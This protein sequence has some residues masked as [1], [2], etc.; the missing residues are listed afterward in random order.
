MTTELATRPHNLVLTDP[1]RSL[2]LDGPTTD[3]TPQVRGKTGGFINIGGNTV[4]VATEWMDDNSRVLVRWLF[5]LAR[6]RE[7][8]WHDFVRETGISQN[9]AYR[10]W[11]D[12]YRYPV[13]NDDGSPNK[14]PKAGQRISLNSVCEKIAKLKRL[15]T[16]RDAVFST[17]FVKIS[18]YDR[19]EWLCRKALVRQKIGFLYSESQMGKT[20]CLK[21]YARLHNGGETSYVEVAPGGGVQF[22]ARL[23]AKALHVN[24]NT[25]YYNLVEDIIKALD[26]SKL[27]IIDEVHR[28]FTV[29]QKNS[30]MK[31]MELL[32]YIY[33]QTHC[34]MVLCGTNVFRDQLEAGPFQQYLKQLKRRGGLYR[35]QLPEAPPLP[36]LHMMADRFGLP[37]ATGKAL[38]ELQHLAKADGFGVVVSTLTDAAEYAARKK[39]RINWGHFLNVVETLT[40]NSKPAK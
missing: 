32:R 28:V 1:E 2:V 3:D 12:K 5:D 14:D 17:G 4:T 10:L 35:V 7:W 36:D 37:N 9:L 11:T 40:K 18:V 6:R 38:E 21:E 27:L 13:K 33:D 16:Q 39:E 30:V 23:I 25:A 15:H 19:V 31:C 22:L 29:F 34:G 26:T 24:P 20:T 8:S